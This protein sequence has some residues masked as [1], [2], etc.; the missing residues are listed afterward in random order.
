MT[1]LKTLYGPTWAYP[2]VGD[3]SIV[4]LVQLCLG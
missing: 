3:T 1:D 4:I 2:V